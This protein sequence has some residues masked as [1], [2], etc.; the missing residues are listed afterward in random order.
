MCAMNQVYKMNYVT[1]HFGELVI[2]YSN[3][4]L[5]KGKVRSESECITTINSNSSINNIANTNM[6]LHYI[7]NNSNNSK[8]LSNTSCQRLL[9]NFNLHNHMKLIIPPYLS[10]ILDKNRIW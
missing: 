5:F 8:Y 6:K 4:K 9:K 3:E 1:S 2:R 10:S 7:K